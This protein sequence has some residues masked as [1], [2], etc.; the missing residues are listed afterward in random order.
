M[1]DVGHAGPW[2]R[3]GQLLLMLVV[4]GCH[5]ERETVQIGWAAV[6]IDGDGDGFGFQ[7]GGGSDCDDSD[8]GRH[9]NCPSCSKPEEGCSCRADAPPTICSL[10]LEL[11]ADQSLVCKSG[12]RYC[13]DRIWSAC[14]DVTRS[15][16][17]APHSVVFQGLVDRDAAPVGCSP[18]QPDCFRIDD[19]LNVA[20]D[21]GVTL[22]TSG[23]ITLPSGTAAPDASTS[24]GSLLDSLL[25]IPGVGSDK[26]CDGI[27]DLY[28]AF[29]T[30]PPFSSDHNTIFM[31]LVPGETKQQSFN[32]AFK[33]NTADIYLYLDMTASMEGERDNLIS[34]LISGNFLPGGGVGIEC[35]DTDFDGLPNVSLTTGGIAANIACLIRDVRIGAGWFRDIPFEGPYANGIKV[36]PN[37]LEMFENRQDLTSDVIAVLSGL[38]TFSTRGNHNVPEGGMQG[39]WSLVTGGEIYAGWDRPG[40]PK[41]EGCPAD[42]WGY[43]CFRNG[44]V[45]IILHITDAP[46]QNGPSPTSAARAGYLSDCDASDQVCVCTKKLC[47]F[48]FCFGCQE[49]TCTCDNNKRHPLNYDANVLADL[50]AGTEATYRKLTTS[51][52]DLATAQPVG[53]IDNVFVTYAGNTDKMASHFTYAATGNCPGS[54]TAWSSSG[55]Q[56]GADAVFSFSVTNTKTLTISTRGSHFDTSLMIKKVGTAAPI[57]C[58]DN[59]ASDPDSEITRSFAPGDYYAIVK[60]R[61]PLTTGW[62]QVT[63]GD[64]SKATS[65]SFTPRK[66]L[67]PLDDGHNGIRAALLARGVKVIT[68]NASLDPYLAEQATALS[69]TTGAVDLLGGALTL[70]IGSDGIGLGLAVLEALNLL[71]NNLSMNVGAV[72]VEAPD[73]PTPDFLFTVEAVDR[74]GDGCSAPIDTDLDAAHLPDTHVSCRPGARPE[75]K[76]RF[77]NRSAPNSVPKNAADANGG[78]NMKLNLIGDGKFVVDSIPVYI[79]PAAVTGGAP[80]TQF[81]EDGKYTQDVAASGCTGTA[82][83]VWRSLRWSATLPEGTSTSWEI[84]SA[85]KESS[86]ASCSFTPVATVTSGSACTSST[87]C[88]TG[89]C[90]TSGFCHYVKGT[91]CAKTADCGAN[92][93]CESG[94]CMYGAPQID[95]GP[96]FGVANPQGKRFARVRAT[97]RASSDRAKAPTVRDW[98]LIYDCAPML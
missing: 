37:D 87:T 6:C 60:G 59:I 11:G 49:Q 86:L 8:P 32:L 93:S 51:A 69:T 33:L 54:T 46:M 17:P 22:A 98:R 48:G 39:L 43:P 56:T 21:S 44:A 18:C 82:L 27:P 4:A 94:F 68:V 76:V 30:S 62:F 89:Y 61:A 14:E 91:A 31:G 16:I 36:A 52:E 2:W 45:P 38:S 50:H 65:T 63:L 29:P 24:G 75:F 80:V 90:D 23:G 97:L 41:R 81:V 58:N 66:W 15:E 79:I 84:C 53:A 26:D 5:E 77:T 42:T 47:V 78:Y 72:L 13:R 35:A 70:Q 73:N 9:M 85:E 19:P 57:D 7:C 95:L 83:P 20:T 71:S 74:L 3:R 28:D 64:K 40:I 10:P 67:G 34:S 55:S 96:A 92:G 88:P 1:S 25:C 12:T